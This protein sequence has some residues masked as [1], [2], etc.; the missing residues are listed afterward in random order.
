MLSDSSGLHKNLSIDL[1]RCEATNLQA[2]PWLRGALR[3]LA[4]TDRP[5][6]EP[7]PLHV[8]RDEPPD[9][10]FRPSRW[11][12]RAGAAEALGGGR[13]PGQGLSLQGQQEPEVFAQRLCLRPSVCL[14]AR[15]SVCLNARADKREMSR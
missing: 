11:I 4:V 6:T 12:L 3:H 10:V 1:N 15:P 8:P 9:V 14:N 2:G 13:G 5:R 7:G